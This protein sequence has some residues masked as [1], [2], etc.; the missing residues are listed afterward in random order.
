MTTNATMT[1]AELR[2]VA[3]EACVACGASLAMANSLV[4]AT[5]S[6]AW[7]G[8]PSVGFPHFLDYLQSLRDGR[9]DGAAMPKIDR[10]LPAV[11]R[12]D[13]GGGIAQLGFDRAI[14][15]LADRA[16]TFGVAMF[17]QKNSYT[18]GEIGYYTRRLAELGLVSFAAA[19]A[20]AMVATAASRGPVYG[21]N[22]FSFGA[23]RPAPQPPLV[24]DQA[25]SAT[26]FVNI[27]KAAADG[28]SIPDGWAID[29]HGAPTTDPAKA[30]LGALLPFGGAKGANVALMVEVL[31]SGLAGGSWSLDAGNFRSGRRSPS[32]ALTIVAIAPGAVAPDFECRL[33]RQLERLTG[34]GVHISGSGGRGTPDQNAV[35]EMDSGTLASIRDFLT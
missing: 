28:R 8:R 2:R 29:Q 11:I 26:A 5:L 4:E 33:E 25:S 1:V 19:N 34:L 17:T 3:T 22:P 13:A 30:L 16:Q 32:T 27:V 23:P 10:P 15:G 14:E 12:C 7:N 20:H 31:S 24:I 9:I 18:A 21:T 6:A 35:L